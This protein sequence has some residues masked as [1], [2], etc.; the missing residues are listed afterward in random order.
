MKKRQVQ[1]VYIALYCEDYEG[2]SR[3]AIF[4]SK[5]KAAAYAEEYGM[6]WIGPV[7]IDGQMH[8]LY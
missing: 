1:K 6:S 3:A 4:R 2:P 7:P 8:N 5:K